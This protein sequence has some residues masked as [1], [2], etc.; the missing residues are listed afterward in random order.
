MSGYMHPAQRLRH[1]RIKHHE[2]KLARDRAER[3][4]KDMARTIRALRKQVET[5][6]PAYV[7]P[8]PKLSPGEQRRA[9]LER[10]LHAFDRY[11]KQAAA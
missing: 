5:L 1:E 8:I 10:E 6:K 11:R 3:A 4:A 9:V 7:P 2:D